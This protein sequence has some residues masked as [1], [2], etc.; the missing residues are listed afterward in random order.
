MPRWLPLLLATLFVAA[1]IYLADSRIVP[2][3]FGFVTGV[4]GLDKLG[5]FTL[6]GGL[7]WCANYALGFRRFQIGPF[8]LLAG[9]IVVLILVVLE[10]ASQHWIPSRTCDWKDLVADLAGIW[11]AGRLCPRLHP[12]PRPVSAT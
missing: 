6:M 4:P 5:H 9:S 8:A 12:A 3:F 1:I 7:A 2:G 11:C 10:E